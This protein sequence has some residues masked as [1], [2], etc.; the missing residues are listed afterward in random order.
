MNSIQTIR[1]RL[2]VTQ[3]AMAAG[4]GVTQGNV[5]NYE[6]GQRMP[7]DVAGRLIEYAKSIG[8]E[9]TYDDVYRAP[10]QPESQPQ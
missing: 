1:A 3:A 9:I 4:I 10:P 5:S 8:H 2:G 7:P 6:R